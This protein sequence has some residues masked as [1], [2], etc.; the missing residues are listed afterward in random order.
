MDDSIAGLFGMGF[1]AISVDNVVPFWS[2]VI[3][4]GTLPDPV[5]T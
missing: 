3:S 2:N 5:F 1:Q 4:D